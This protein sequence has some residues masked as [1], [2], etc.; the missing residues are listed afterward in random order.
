[1][2]KAPF[3]R[4][5]LGT[6]VFVACAR[7]QD[8]VA[9]ADLAPAAPAPSAPAEFFVAAANGDVAV[10]K[11]C[12][13]EGM[14][15]DAP[16]PQPPPD[17]LLATF[18]PKSRGGL[19]L[20]DPGATALMLATAA[21]KIDAMEFL[22]GA[23]AN[24]EARTKSNV[25]PLDIAAERGDTTAMQMLLG[26]TP[27]SDAA[28]L[29]ITIDLTKQRAVLTRDGQ[30]VLST[31]VSSGRKDKPTPPGTYIVTQ[32]YTEWRSTL[33]HNASM[34]FF[35]RLSCSAVGLHAGVVPDYPAS[36]GCVRVPAETA[37]KLY[38][39]I[40]RGTLVVIR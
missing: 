17:E 29:A 30:T 2:L 35:L 6:L 24:R 8:P 36:H 38:E 9:P 39:I 19:L 32:K 11:R 21:G 13:D 15:V 14:P 22:L 27:E 7:A 10:M 26:V 40:P 3:L 18:P 4:G 33:Y 5:L 23:K 25:R 12:L 31:K 28:H 20:R 37:K 16:A 1:M 34:P